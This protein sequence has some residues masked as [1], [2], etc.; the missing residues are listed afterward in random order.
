MRA[1]DLEKMAAQ[2]LEQAAKLKQMAAELRGE[3]ALT[4]EQAAAMFRCTPGGVLQH[5]ALRKGVH[6]VGQPARVVQVPG[7]GPCVLVLG[8]AYKVD[9]LRGALGWRAPVTALYTGKDALL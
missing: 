1:E 4:L 9:D 5:A 3:A 6:Y 8:E 2:C 7:R